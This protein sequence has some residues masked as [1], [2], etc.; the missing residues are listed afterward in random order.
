M[1]ARTDVR[2]QY[3]AVRE[4]PA[5]TQLVLDYREACERLAQDLLT[6]ENLIKSALVNQVVD[7]FT[8]TTEPL[9]RLVK[10][11][12]VR[13]KVIHMFPLTRTSCFLSDLSNL[14]V[15]VV[16]NIDVILWKQLQHASNISIDIFS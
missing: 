2:E 6:M 8:E 14:Y 9:D 15:H 10:T 7:I 4:N 11:A 12:T 5:F 13:L 3:D 1:Q 16:Q